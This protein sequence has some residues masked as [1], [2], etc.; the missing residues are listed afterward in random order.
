MSAEDP[1]RA[2]PP[3]SPDALDPNEP[4]EPNGQSDVPEE[5]DGGDLW[6]GKLDRLDR[7]PLAPSGSTPDVSGLPDL[8]EELR[9]VRDRLHSLEI[10]VVDASARTQAALSAAS[11]TDGVTSRLEAVERAL[12]RRLSSIEEELSG[13]GDAASHLRRTSGFVEEARAALSEERSAARDAAR[14]F[15]EVMVGALRDRFEAIDSRFEHVAEVLAQLAGQGQAIRE[16]NEKLEEAAAHAEASANQRVEQLRRAMAGTIEALK[17]RL[18]GVNETLDEIRGDSRALKEAVEAE[19]TGRRAAGEEGRAVGESTQERFA[20]IE[21]ALGGLVGVVRQ[22]PESLGGLT[23]NVSGLRETV[24]AERGRTSEELDR[25]RGSLTG[26]LDALHGR[27]DESARAVEQLA[28]SVEGQGLGETFAQDQERVAQA[29]RALTGTLSEQMAGLPEAL[30]SAVEERRGLGTDEESL[31]KLRDAVRE[32]GERLRAGLEKVLAVRSDTEA[33]RELGGR[34]PAVVEE[35]VVP[36]LEAQRD[37]VR[38]LAERLPAELEELVASRFDEQRAMLKDVG[39]RVPNEIE[40]LRAGLA[41]LPPAISEAARPLATD[42]DGIRSDLTGGIE[43]VR[44]GLERAIAQTM[45]GVTSGLSR[46]ES[47]LA[48]LR[49]SS[50]SEGRAVGGVL[51]EA[52]REVSRSLEE[53]LGAVQERV[54]GRIG[55]TMEA[56]R[57]SVQELAGGLRDELS[58]TVS[59]LREERERADGEM[60]SRVEK[61]IASLS[62]A[63]TGTVADV[64]AE[65]TGAIGSV[66]KVLAAIG[67]Q[68]R[69]QAEALSRLD[70]RLAALGERVEEME[71]P[72]VLKQLVQTEQQVLRQQSAFVQRLEGAGEALVEHG[73][74]IGER[75]GGIATELDG[76]VR[77]LR[78]ETVGDLERFRVGLR[79]ALGALWK[80]VAGTLQGLRDHIEQLAGPRSDIEA[81]GTEL[82]A[83]GLELR[84]EVKSLSSHLSSLQG[85]F[86]E[87]LRSIDEDLKG[88]VGDLERRIVESVTREMDRRFEATMRMIQA[89]ISEVEAASQSQL[90]LAETEP[91]PEGR[92]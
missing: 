87:R 50:D 65:V 23:E 43:S 20:A 30:V 71:Q 72:A 26:S 62:A 8:V 59:R 83:T 67:G 2:R 82:E 15:G 11:K 5:A 32:L 12:E 58:A 6:I 22:L 90:P 34:L 10:S 48:A 46:L 84:G 86:E 66:Q 21:G 4:S 49:A 3:D 17:D 9:E 68:A 61:A 39:E 60:K 42:V 76:T 55:E 40:Q 57:G 16:T 38:E 35:T 77:G 27:L 14:Q 45:E 80:E 78:A 54:D 53:R 81:V 47:D 24:R 91:R 1:A 29:L 88:G 79:E 92:E 75:L 25:V 56:T 51:L 44:L 37:A 33:V 19:A 70:A 74:R 18:R 52:L 31:G 7:E 89:G 36:R 28:S 64:R 85:S 73:D 63:T 13:V 41:A 69:K